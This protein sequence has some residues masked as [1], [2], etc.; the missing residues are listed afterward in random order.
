M[1]GVR[2][3]DGL[4]RVVREVLIYRFVFNEEN[5]ICKNVLYEIV[6]N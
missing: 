1:S 4:D 5:I 2:G 6:V 3:V